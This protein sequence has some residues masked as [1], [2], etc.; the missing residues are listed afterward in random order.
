MTT[1]NQNI[2]TDTQTATGTRDHSVLGHTRV[3]TALSKN[4]I[5]VTIKSA[6]EV[7]CGV[8]IAKF[9]EKTITIEAVPGSRRLLFRSAINYLEYPLPAA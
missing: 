9:D 5:P 4:R 6:G 8:E 2:G 3:L 7:L 1:I